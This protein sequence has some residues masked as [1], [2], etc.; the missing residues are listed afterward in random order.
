MCARCAPAARRRL[1]LLLNCSS[2]SGCSARARAGVH[3]V[4]VLRREGEKRRAG[5]WGRPAC[6]CKSIKMRWR[7]LR[8][9][10]AAAAQCVA[11]KVVFE[12]ERGE[13]RR[14]RGAVG[15]VCICVCVCVSAAA[16]AAARAAE[17]ARARAAHKTHTQSPLSLCL[18][19]S[20]RH[21]QTK[22]HS[23]GAK[24]WRGVRSKHELLVRAYMVAIIY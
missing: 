4:Q 17:R 20:L 19:V 15:C 6:A 8:R 22:Q 14:E 16:A 13:E 5:A 1:L 18:A 21:G 12:R 3:S 10:D 7:P 24:M 11:S 9:A 2:S 23:G